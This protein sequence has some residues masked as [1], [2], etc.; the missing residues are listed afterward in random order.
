MDIFT[1]IQK[2]SSLL[3]YWKK[4]CKKKLKHFGKLTYAGPDNSS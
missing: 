2:N 4:L 1:K 3:S